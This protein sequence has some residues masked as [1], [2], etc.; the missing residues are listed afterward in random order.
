MSFNDDRVT[1]V[2]SRITGGPYTLYIQPH[3]I[4]QTRYRRFGIVMH[5]SLTLQSYDRQQ[6]QA[7]E[8]G[9]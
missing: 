9:V 5:I 6:R 4:K 2:Q 1:D 8:D 7:L 3:N